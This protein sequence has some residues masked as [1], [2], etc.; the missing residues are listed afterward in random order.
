MN[1]RMFIS[2]SGSSSPYVTDANRSRIDPRGSSLFPS[3]ESERQTV[4]DIE[5]HVV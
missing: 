4:A 5:S 2:E 3:D 1:V